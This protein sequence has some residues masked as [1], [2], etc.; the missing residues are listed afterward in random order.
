MDATEAG[1]LRALCFFDA[2][3]Y[4]PTQAEWCLAFDR[5]QGE[6]ETTSLAYVRQSSQRLL[7]GGRVLLVRGRVCFSGRS[8]L[9]EQSEARASWMPRKLR[10]AE[11][12]VSWLR[13]LKGIRFVALCNTTAL[14]TA[15]EDAD[16][17]FFVVVRRGTLWQTRLL[18][19]LPFA[20][21]RRWDRAPSRRR[22][23][24]VRRRDACSP[25]RRYAGIPPCSC[26]TRCPSSRR[27]RLC[28][29][30]FR[31]ARE[32]CCA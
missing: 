3:S 27:I 30:C 16:L 10:Q 1:L 26:R 28:R 31:A 6:G 12:V 24:R 21:L 4:A 13:R 7:D 25:V 5:G 19:A 20:L 29:V 15:R 2:L 9:I 32:N 14:G 18:A 23:R 17:D 8:I 22:L 11:R